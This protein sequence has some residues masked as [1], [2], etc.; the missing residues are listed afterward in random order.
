MQ[1]SLHIC[2]LYEL[3][4]LPAQSCFL[5]FCFREHV[6]QATGW[7]VRKLRVKL[8]VPFLYWL[9][10]PSPALLFFSS[11]LLYEEGLVIFF[12]FPILSHLFH[13]KWMKAPI[14]RMPVGMFCKSWYCMNIGALIPRQK[15]IEHADWFREQ[16]RKRKKK[17]KQNM[18]ASDSGSWA[19]VFITKV[20]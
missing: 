1:T 11:Q 10:R 19:F 5:L 9:V 7:G 18:W 16:E 13:R 20:G 6:T 15:E 17:K 4:K 14:C 2:N 8:T 12:S 3:Y